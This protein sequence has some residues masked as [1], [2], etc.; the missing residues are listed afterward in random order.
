MTTNDVHAGT[1][2]ARWSRLDSAFKRFDTLAWT[3][4]RVTVGVVMMAHGSLKLADPVGTQEFFASAG[5]PLPATMVWLAVA[6]EFL[7]GLGV[8]V[9][10]LTRLAAAGVLCVMAGAI[11]SVHLGNGLMASNN[12]F[13]YP[14][15]LLMASLAFI[16]RGPGPVSIDAVVRQRWENRSRSKHRAAATTHPENRAFQGSR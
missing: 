5:L 8:L 16:A 3:L 12:G 13:E 1:S 11:F 7:G 10:A 14:L 2:R 4:L 15:V 9:G 6:G